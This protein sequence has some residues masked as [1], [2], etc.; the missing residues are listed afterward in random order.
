MLALALV[1]AGCASS[2]SNGV[3]A[4]QVEME[5]DDKFIECIDRVFQ[6]EDQ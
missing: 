4:C 1:L 3:H 5:D 2:Q 6:K